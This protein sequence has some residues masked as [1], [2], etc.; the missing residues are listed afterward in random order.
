[1]SHV[2]GLTANILWGL[3]PVYYY[4]LKTID[5]ERMLAYRFIFTFVILLLV[6]FA[7]K[8]PVSLL[9]LKRSLI[10]A[11]LLTINAYVY[12]VTVLTGHVL[13][14]AYGYLITPIL[15]IL[16]GSVFFDERCTRAQAS[17][18]GVCIISIVYY[19]VAVG[20][21]PWFGIG[22]A[23]PFALYLTWH[24]FQQTQSSLDALRHESIIMLVLPIGYFT[25]LGAEGGKE[26][27]HELAGSK[28]LVIAAS[29]LVTVLPLAIFVGACSK[30]KTIYIGTYQFVAP[31]I[32]AIVAIL[33]FDHPL[34]AAKLSMGLGLALG[35][36]L[37][38]LPFDKI[39]W[40][41]PG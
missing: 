39:K 28:G 32:S 31:M 36:A 37:A 18:I 11:A 15:T 30:L 17:G 10:P 38:V 9:T 7:Q 12:I 2:G 26:V 8:K 3:V 23:L 5:T 35:M 20:T 41:Q 4:F 13:E 21:L 1:M 22:I 33:L 25:L 14:A 6:G 27:L 16:C 40:S 24:K 29:G 34:T 19:A